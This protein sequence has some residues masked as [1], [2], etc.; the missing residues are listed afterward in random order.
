MMVGWKK[1]RLDEFVKFQR[2]FDLPK[3]KQ[4]DTET[5]RKSVRLLS[6]NRRFLRNL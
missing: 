3:G 6:K 2:G 1:I 5:R 4:L